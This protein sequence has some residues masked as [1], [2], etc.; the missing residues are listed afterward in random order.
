MKEFGDVMLEISQNIFDIENKRYEII[1]N[2]AIAIITIVG[3]LTTF[4]IGFVSIENYKMIL[5]P[6]L[7]SFAMSVVFSILVL[8]PTGA[9]FLNFNKLVD[10]YDGTPQNIQITGI[11][12]TIWKTSKSMRKACNTKAWLLFISLLFLVAGII[13]L[14]IL[15]LIRIF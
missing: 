15:S 12:E 14:I 10:K 13:S 8:F 5:F 2:K 7:G 11:A 4:L 9:H 1:D 3:I 6:I